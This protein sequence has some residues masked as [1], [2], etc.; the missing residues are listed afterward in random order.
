MI[1]L[2]YHVWNNQ[3][4]RSVPIQLSTDM[5]AKKLIICKSLRLILL[6]VQLLNL[7]ERNRNSFREQFKTGYAHVLLRNGCTCFCL[8]TGMAWLALCAGHAVIVFTQW[9]KNGFFA[10]QGRLVA[11]INVKFGTG[12]GP[13]LRY[14]CQIKQFV[15]HKYGN[16]APKTVNILNF[17]HKFAPQGSLVCTILTKFSGFCTR[18]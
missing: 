6:L 8:I 18:Q 11:L 7:F 1:C 2:Q 4:S 17:G 13:L 10:P 14:P 9:S 5:S 15:G 16:T 12:S 3:L